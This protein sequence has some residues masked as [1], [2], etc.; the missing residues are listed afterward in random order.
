MFKN[1]N[2]DFVNIYRIAL[3][4]EFL[5]DELIDVNNIFEAINEVDWAINYHNSL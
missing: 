1:I 4:F 5:N 3:A 2:L